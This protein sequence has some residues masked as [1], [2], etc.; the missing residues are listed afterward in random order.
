[1]RRVLAL[2][3]LAGLAGCEALVVQNTD[4]PVYG[5]PVAS[6]KEAQA[7]LTNLGFQPGPIDGK[8]GRRTARAVTAYRESRGL[9]GKGGIDEAL[10]LS[11][12]VESRVNP[13]TPAPE[14]QLVDRM[15][16]PA[17][18][19]A[20]LDEE[21][22]SYQALLVDLDR[23]GDLDMVAVADRAIGVCDRD[24]CPWVILE[25][26]PAGWRKAA[27]FEARGVKI[28]RGRHNGWRDLSALAEDGAVILR[29]DGA[30][31]R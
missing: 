15:W 17:R 7:A 1:M 14:P 11:I 25:N 19:R 26:I 4:A 9:P 29:Y 23:D 31:Y 3:M 21:W 20:P 28:R 10:S 16:L 13:G 18:N 30:F 2:I 5:S 24:L 22:L 6:V 8:A 12:R 27:V